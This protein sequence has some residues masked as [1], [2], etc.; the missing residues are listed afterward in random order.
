MHVVNNL[1]ACCQFLTATRKG[2]STNRHDLCDNRGQIGNRRGRSKRTETAAI[3]AESELGLKAKS[4]MDAGQLVS[5]DIMIGMISERMDAPDC[6]NGVILDG[7]PRTVAQAEALD[8]MFADKNIALDSVIEIAVDEAALF[9]R[10][11]NRAAET[12]GSRSDDNAE[13]LAERLKVY[14]ANTA[15]ILPYYKDKNKLVTIDGMQSIDKVSED[16]R[17]VMQG[18]T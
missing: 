10:I 9:A 12:G 13:V 11:E 4:I 1:A 3:A 14:H 16:I 17:S 7:F 18:N 6:A 15:P 8:L 5:D 2:G